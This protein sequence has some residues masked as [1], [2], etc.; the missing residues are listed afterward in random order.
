[1]KKPK[2]QKPLSNTLSSPMTVRGTCL[3]GLPEWVGGEC[4]SGTEAVQLCN[5]GSYVLPVTLCQ[6]LG[7][8]AGASCINGTTAA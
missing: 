3:S 5:T 4:E 8:E 1:M 2:Y 7:N 6:P